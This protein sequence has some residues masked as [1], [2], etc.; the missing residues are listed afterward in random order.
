MCEGSSYKI[1]GEDF[2]K[3][4]VSVAKFATLQIFLALV[5]YLDW[6]LEQINIV[7]SFL[8]GELEE[9]IYMEVPEEF[10][11]FGDG[12]TYWKLLKTLYGLKQARR[13]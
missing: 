5:A 12:K 1:P 11:K 8:N 13:Q 6:D 4:F 2:T 9:E 10:K 7:A 3:T